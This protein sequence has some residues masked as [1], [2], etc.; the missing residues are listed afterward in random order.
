MDSNCRAK[1]TL[2]IAHSSCSTSTILNRGEQPFEEEHSTSGKSQQTSKFERDHNSKQENSVSS[3]VLIK[4]QGHN[5]TFEA[6]MN[7]TKHSRNT[8]TIAQKIKRPTMMP[9]LRTTV[10]SWSSDSCRG[11]CNSFEFISLSLLSYFAFTFFH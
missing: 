1:G 8:N 11:M 2:R 5:F 3:N 6:K 10:M 4:S 9:T 7:M